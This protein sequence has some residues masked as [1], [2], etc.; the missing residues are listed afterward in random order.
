MKKRHE[1]DISNYSTA[2]DTINEI[3]QAIITLKSQHGVTDNKIFFESV[4]EEI[5][6]SNG[7]TTIKVCIYCRT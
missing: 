1:I 4:T 6:Y 2:L 7:Q 5:P 3:Q